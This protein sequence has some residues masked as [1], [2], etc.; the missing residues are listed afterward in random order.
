MSGLIWLSEQT[1]LGLPCG[2]SSW[3]LNRY[4]GILF[5]EFGIDDADTVHPDIARL[6]GRGLMSVLGDRKALF[7][8]RGANA[9]IRVFAGLRV[10]KDW[11]ETVG[12]DLSSGG[13]ILP[14]WR[15]R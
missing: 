7:V 3:M 15:R 4:C 8:Y 1:A 2:H 12:L 10:P 14:V 5:V 13:T 6:V 9:H 11:I